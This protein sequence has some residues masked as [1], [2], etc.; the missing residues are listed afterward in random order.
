MFITKGRNKYATQGRA[1]TKEKL[2]WYTGQIQL[3][4]PVTKYVK[5]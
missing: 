4:Q 1:L 3:G 2:I 5:L